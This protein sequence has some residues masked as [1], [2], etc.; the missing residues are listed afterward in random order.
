MATLAELWAPFTDDD[1]IDEFLHFERIE[2]P[3]HPRPDV[4][5]FLILHDLVPGTDNMIAD[6]KHD[7]FFL[8]TDCDKLAA[9]IA[10]EQIRDLVRCGV[11]Y[12]EGVDSLA[13]FS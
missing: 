1:D 2:N 10:P 12:D 7:E 3:R 9:V 5:A 11:R 4:C 8:S 13:M 6:A